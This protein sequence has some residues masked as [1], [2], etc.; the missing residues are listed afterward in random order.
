MHCNI[1]FVILVVLLARSVHSFVPASSE[2]TCTTTLNVQPGTSNLTLLPNFI[3]P[4]SFWY[5]RLHFVHGLVCQQATEHHVEFGGPHTV[6]EL[7]SRAVV[8]FSSR[9][10]PQRVYSLLVHCFGWVA[11]HVKLL[12]RTCQPSHAPF[13]GGVRNRAKPLRPCPGLTSVPNSEYCGSLTTC[14]NA[15]MA[16]DRQATGQAR[17]AI[18][19]VVLHVVLD[20]LQLEGW[21]HEGCSWRA[22]AWVCLV[23][24]MYEHDHNTLTCQ[25]MTIVSQLCMGPNAHTLDRRRL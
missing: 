18:R 5:V 12:D 14:T 6:N 7:I 15:F 11:W 2:I 19:H 9:R 17:Q 1:L 3:G 4:G 16:C 22:A 10:I 13:A 20:G 23:H 21:V 25:G 8:N 24:A